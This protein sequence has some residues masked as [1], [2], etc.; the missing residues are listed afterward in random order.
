L[1]HFQD[2]RTERLEFPIPEKLNLF[3]R[4]LKWRFRKW[5]ATYLCNPEMSA[6]WPDAARYVARCALQERQEERERTWPS[7]IGD[8]PAANADNPVMVALLKQVRD[9]KAGKDSGEGVPQWRDEAPFF[10]YKVLPEEDLR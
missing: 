6:I 2:G 9:L 7:K 5:Q 3:D 10:I 1:V 4:M 8:Q